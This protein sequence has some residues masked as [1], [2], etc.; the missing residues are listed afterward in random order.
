M[1]GPNFR[2]QKSEIRFLAEMSHPWYSLFTE[3]PALR[4]YCSCL[5]CSLKHQH[6]G[7]TA[8]AFYVH[9]NTSIEEVLLMP[10]M[11]TETPALRKYCSCLL[12]SLKHQ[13]WGSI[14]H[15]FH[16]HWNASI[17]EV[18]LMPSM[19]TETPALRKYCSCLLW[20]DQNTKEYRFTQ[21]LFTMPKRKRYLGHRKTMPV[22]KHAKVGV[23]IKVPSHSLLPQDTIQHL[24]Q[25][26]R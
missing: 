9:W 18:L 19:F 10:S 1:P 26:Y 7:S 12:C 17:E 21:Y 24:K 6:W 16:V 20:T 2:F 15:A 13:H 22:M 11:F 25:Y 14:A 3:T 4:K 8:H 23:I 5:L